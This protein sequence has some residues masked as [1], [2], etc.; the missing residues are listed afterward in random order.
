MSLKKKNGSYR[1][2]DLFSGGGGF[3]RGFHDEGFTTLLALDNDK[4]AAKTFKYNFPH[5]IVINEDI[6]QVETSLIEKLVGTGIDVLLGSPPCE[7][8]TKANPNIMKK[9]LD[10]LYTDPVGRLVL[11]FVKYVDILRPR[12][13]V[14]ENVTGLM[15]GP[16]RKALEEEFRRIGYNRVYFNVLR[17]EDHCTP[18]R[19]NRVFISNIPLNTRK[20]GRIITVREVL[21]D[22]PPPNKECPPNHEPPP[23][24]PRKE[25]KIARVKPGRALIYYRGFGGRRLPN[26]IKLEPDSVAP[27]VLGSSRFLHPFEPRFL[28]VR[29]Q[30]RLMGYPDYHVFLGGRDS[31]YNM[32][33]ESVPPPL[34]RSIAQV[35]KEYLAK[36]AGGENDN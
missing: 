30:A 5:T 16:L 11:Y 23:T 14:M 36:E 12:V 31:Q 13:F 22:L 15:E 7:P 2:V 21:A 18:S 25:K 4:N 8:F 29:E 24:S 9:P 27:T 6:K 17:A 35:V 10:R 1:V 3:S 19:R 26:L 20:C 34:A 32:V 28:T 33:G